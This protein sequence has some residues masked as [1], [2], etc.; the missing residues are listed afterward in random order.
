[1]SVEDNKALLRRFNEE[2]FNKRN[3]ASVD[4]LIASNQIDHSLPPGLPRTREGTRQAISMT[5]MAFPDLN[6]VV[7]DIIAEGDKVVTRYTTRGTQRGSLGR[8]PPTGRQV[9]VPGIVIARI[10]DGKI[11]EQWGLDD[12]LDMLQQLGV[13]PALFGFVLLTGLLAGMGLT[14]FLRKASRKLK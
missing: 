8:F 10:A 4:A 6:F 9:A 1:M 2:V 3:L 11:V 5:L 14:F 12:R 7:E 13:I